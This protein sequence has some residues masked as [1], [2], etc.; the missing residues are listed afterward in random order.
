[1]LTSCPTEPVSA[2]WPALDA[3]SPH[4]PAGLPCQVMGPDLWFGETPAELDQAKKFCGDCPARLVCLAGALA[5]REHWG[6]W[7]GEIFD[8]GQ[9]VARK[10]VR[11]R[12]RKSD[13][14]A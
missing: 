11:G 9:T 1:M 6:V 3:V 13:V 7:G 5:R 10:R 4:G 14:A 2:V 8:R 12:P